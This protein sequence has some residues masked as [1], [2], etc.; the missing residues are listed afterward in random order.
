MK[1]SP[2]PS[3]LPFCLWMIA[4]TLSLADLILRLTKGHII[5]DILYVPVAVTVLFSA[6]TL[7]YLRRYQKEQKA[8]KAAE[9]VETAAVADSSQE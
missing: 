9:A 4:D 6:M 8:V 3:L 7:I 2:T 5:P 1:S